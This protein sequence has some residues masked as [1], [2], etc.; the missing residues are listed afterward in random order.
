M[1]VFVVCGAGFELR[2]L[3]WGGCCEAREAHLGESGIC[4]T[5][6][7]IRFY[8]LCIIASSFSFSFFCFVAPSAFIISKRVDCGSR[9]FFTVFRQFETPRDPMTITTTRPHLTLD[10]PPTRRRAPLL[11]LS[12]SAFFRGALPLCCSSLAVLS[13]CL[14]ARLFWCLGVRVL[15]LGSRRPHRPHHRHRAP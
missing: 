6:H 13:P 7:V 8:A 2:V 9:R 15:F 4:N 5:Q 1:I 14:S 10:G 3:A 11:S 12:F